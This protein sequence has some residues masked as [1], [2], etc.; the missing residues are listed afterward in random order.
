MGDSFSKATYTFLSF[1]LGSSFD[2]PQHFP[3]LPIVDIA[4]G[5]FSI[6]QGTF[7]IV[8][9][10]FSTSSAVLQLPLLFSLLKMLCQGGVL[11]TLVFSSLYC[12]LAYF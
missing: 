5:T 6:V 7:G 1:R 12:Y 8:Q 2:V 11:S 10:T 3:L 9:G 4:Q